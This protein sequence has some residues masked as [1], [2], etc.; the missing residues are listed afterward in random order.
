MEPEIRLGHKSPPLWSQHFFIDW[1]Y[2]TSPS[3]APSST[4][5]CF[6]YYPSH[7]FQFSIYLL[8]FGRSS[9]VLLK[10]RERETRKRKNGDVVN[11]PRRKKQENEV[12]HNYY[13][14]FHSSIHMG[15]RECA[16]ACL[17]CSVY[18]SLAFQ[19]TKLFRS[20]GNSLLQ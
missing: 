4:C 6:F 1:F 14:S 11:S 2:F 18:C 17:F 5:I 9:K 3:L 16:T 15:F 12:Y 8:V 13:L 20:R 19:R 7:R 10:T